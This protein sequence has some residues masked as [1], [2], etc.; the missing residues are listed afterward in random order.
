[1]THQ[2]SAQK[3]EPVGYENR[4]A[5]WLIPAYR[6]SRLHISGFFFGLG[7]F[8]TRSSGISVIGLWP[9]RPVARLQ[10]RLRFF[11]IVLVLVLLIRHWTCHM[12][13]PPKT[14][15]PKKPPI[16]PAIPGDDVSGSIGLIQEKLI[17]RAVVEWAK[18]EA[19]MGDAITRL[20]GL[21]FEYGRLIVS[22]MDATALIKTLRD[23][24]ALRLPQEKFNKLS[25][26][27]M[28]TTKTA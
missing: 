12:E 9:V 8:A 6:E 1:L 3:G 11:V 25:V 13:K 18:L 2:E 14:P 21:E 19:C 26:I 10:A 27:C 22:R 16:Q 24:G 20:F 17:G 5:S 23:A 28:H 15:R 4:A 7:F